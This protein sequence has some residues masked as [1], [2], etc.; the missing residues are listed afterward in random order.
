MDQ[1]GPEDQGGDHGRD[2][3]DRARERAADR[4]G[5][6]AVSRLERHPHADA[7]RHR[8]EPAEGRA[9]PGSLR[10]TGRAA[11]QGGPAARAA[12]RQITGGQQ[13]QR[14]TGDEGQARAE[15]GQV[16]VCPRVRLGQPGR[17]DR[18]QR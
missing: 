5:G 1:A 2:R 11:V 17:A 3:H 6:P 18:H 10:R 16:D 15:D 4:H 8:S 7:A 14:Q 9:E 12:F 13:Q